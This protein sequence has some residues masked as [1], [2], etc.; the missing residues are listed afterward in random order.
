MLL[1]KNLYDLYSGI[2]GVS[3]LQSTMYR[4]YYVQSGNINLLFVFVGFFHITHSPSPLYYV[5]PWFNQSK[6]SFEI[7]I[8]APC[9]QKE[10]KI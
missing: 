1:I 8:D 9:F 10:R 7:R 5:S 3:T 6:K 4:N 2:S